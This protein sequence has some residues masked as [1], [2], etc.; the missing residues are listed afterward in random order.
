M[1]QRSHCRTPYFKAEPIFTIDTF[2]HLCRV[3]GNPLS[4][5][6]PSLQGAMLKRANPWCEEI[7]DFSAWPV[8]PGIELKLSICRWL[9][10]Q[11]P[12]YSAVG[13]DADVLFEMLMVALVCIKKK[14]WGQ[15]VASQKKRKKCWISK[16]ARFLLFLL[17]L[18]VVKDHMPG[19]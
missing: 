16:C 4:L 5:V 1:K 6:L 17:G 14:N 10:T 11:L 15:K 13:L 12:A 8:V 18:E 7:E 9:Y 19:W 2:I 3:I